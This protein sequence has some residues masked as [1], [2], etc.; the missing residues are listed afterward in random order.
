MLPFH[1]DYAPY[2]LYHLSETLQILFFTVIGFFLLAEML[3][4]K[5][6]LS[7]DLDFPYRLGGKYLMKFLHY[8]FPENASVRRF[9][10]GGV[11][12]FG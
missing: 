11:H 8:C 4:P 6:G 1:V 12:I 2:N 3:K 9:L 10:S 7:I 5:P